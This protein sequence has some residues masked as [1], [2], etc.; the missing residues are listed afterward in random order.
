MFCFH[1][2]RSDSE[3]FTADAVV[4]WQK[5]GVEADERPGRMTF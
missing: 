1:S 3:R 4:D 2:V 5:F